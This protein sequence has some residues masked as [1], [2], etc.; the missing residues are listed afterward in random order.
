MVSGALVDDPARRLEAVDAREVDV[1]QDELRP[2]VERRGDRCLAGR[3]L[4]DHLEAG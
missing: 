2:A 1:H 3:G 4:R